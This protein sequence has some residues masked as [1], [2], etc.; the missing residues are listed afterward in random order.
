MHRCNA[1]T[2]LEVLVSVTIMVILMTITTTA[3]IP[4]IE[5][6]KVEETR[7][8]LLELK[9][10]LQKYYE[11]IGEFPEES[12]SNTLRDLIGYS[13]HS[14]DALAV[15]PYDDQNP[16][17]KIFYGNWR[18]HGPFI[19]AG[20]TSRDYLYDG[21]KQPFQY[22]VPFPFDESG[23]YDST[24]GKKR[25]LLYSVG[26][27]GKDNLRMHD[28]YVDIS[29]ENDI[30]LIIIPREPQ[31]KDVNIIQVPYGAELTVVEKEDAT[32]IVIKV[33]ESNGE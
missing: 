9:E 8:T 30:N 22:I 7:T 23:K 5:G 24:L 11:V 21:W 12:P 29:W 27:D 25:A 3:M 26:K 18:D 20:F 28:P 19:S 32:E 14:L 2:L 16:S 1:F 15:N 33:Q 17:E 13:A 4:V 10:A 6:S 31:E